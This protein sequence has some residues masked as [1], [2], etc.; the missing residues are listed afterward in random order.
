MDPLL[1]GDDTGYPSN[2]MVYFFLFKKKVKQPYVTN[3][4]LRQL[5]EVLLCAAIF[6][7]LCELLWLRLYNR[8]CQTTS[9][10]RRIPHGCLFVDIQYIRLKQPKSSD[11]QSPAHGQRGAP[12]CALA[13]R[14]AYGS[15]NLQDLV[16]STHDQGAGRDCWPASPWPDSSTR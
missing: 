14:P 12:S 16:S 6:L 2:S 3:K 10:H 1:R 8:P 11:Q 13:P 9:F 7:L 4:T 15:H 5:A